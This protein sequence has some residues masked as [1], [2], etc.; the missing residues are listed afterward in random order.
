MK[1]KEKDQFSVTRESRYSIPVGSTPETMVCQVPYLLPLSSLSDQA[2]LLVWSRSSPSQHVFSGRF[3]L[4]A[5]QKGS[6]RS[7]IGSE[8][9]FSGLF[10]YE[11]IPNTWAFSYFK[12][13]KSFRLLRGR[14]PNIMLTQEGGTER[15]TFSLQRACSMTG[16]KRNGIVDRHDGIIEIQKIPTI[17]IESLDSKHSLRSS[18][19][20]LL[21]LQYVHISGLRNWSSHDVYTEKWWERGKKHQ[22]I[23]R[24]RNSALTR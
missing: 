23:S 14:G 4:T 2:N 22:P 21:S 24:I 16:I 15:C 5:L 3:R 18:Q 10:H 13:M 19:C 8:I 11:D 20:W 12:D 7:V 9:G 1:E 17:Y 6:R